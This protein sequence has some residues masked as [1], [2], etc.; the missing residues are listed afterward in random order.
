M[1]EDILILHNIYAC[2]DK[3]L[4][5]YTYIATEVDEV[6][7]ADSYYTMLHQNLNFSYIT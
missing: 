1:N 3:G 2:L 7:L 4:P 6:L 5:K